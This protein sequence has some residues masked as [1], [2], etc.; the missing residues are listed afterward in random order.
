MAD[1]QAKDDPVSRTGAASSAVREDISTLNELILVAREGGEFYVSAAEE[2]QTAR[3]RDLF[4]EMAA[5]RARLVGDLQ[6]HVAAAGARPVEPTSFGMNLRKL[7]VDLLA[8]TADDSDR[9][10]VAQ[11]EEI[12][13][14]LL[15]AFEDAVAEAHAPEVRKVL[16]YHLPRVR[17]SHDRVRAMKQALH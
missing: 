3:L 4:R 14:G 17:A 16:Q 2:V 12:E 10:Y 7:Y 5:A 6:R 8:R 1:E 9:S 11:L 15:E 13:D